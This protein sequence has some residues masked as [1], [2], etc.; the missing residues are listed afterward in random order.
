VVHVGIE[1]TG[2]Y[3]NNW[4][5]LFL[6][7]KEMFNLKVT[8]LNPLCVK[9][10]HEAT[11]RRNVTDDISAYN[12]AS[13]LIAYHNK[14]SYEQDTAFSSTRKQ[15][16]FTRLLL[17]QKTQLV[18]QMG[19]LIYQSH[20][21][22]VRHCKDGVPQWIIKLLFKYP[23]AKKLAGA[24]AAMVAKIPYISI[25]KADQL[26]KDAQRS[27]ASRLMKLIAL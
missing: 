8:R 4:F 3:E 26:I 16:K 2:G 9:K 17:K 15:W 21:E 5:G 19:F 20:P 24:K 10:H 7:L 25:E 6:R 23:T 1:S 18:N 11:L 13:Y 12:I 22:L 14:V 27:V